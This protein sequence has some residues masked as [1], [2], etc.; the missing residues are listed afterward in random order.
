MEESLKPSF[1]PACDKD[2]AGNYSPLVLAFQG[3]AVYELAI[4]TMLLNQ[5]NARPNDLNRRKS[6]LVKAAAQSKMMEIIMPYLT[7]E[8]EA[9]YKRGRNA[10]SATMAKNASV[11]DYRRATGFEALIG[12]LYLSGQKDRLLELITK[13][14]EGY[15]QN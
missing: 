14:V 11:A 8:E 3:D 2:E 13:G 15:G 6:A 5:G 9:V 12:Y 4:R 1:L 7:G 10:R